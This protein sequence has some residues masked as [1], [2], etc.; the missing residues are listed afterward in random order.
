VSSKKTLLDLIGND[1]VILLEE[2]IDSYGN[3]SLHDVLDIVYQ[4]ELVKSSD[5][6]TPLDFAQREFKANEEEVEGEVDIF[7]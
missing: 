7:A 4:L 3:M 1:K 6:N 5:K 2:V